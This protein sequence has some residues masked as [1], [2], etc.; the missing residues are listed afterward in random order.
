M[1]PVFYENANIERYVGSC[2]V[3]LSEKSNGRKFTQFNRNQSLHRYSWLQNCMAERLNYM[4]VRDGWSGI[5]L[6]SMANSGGKSDPGSYK[7]I[8]GKSGSMNGNTSNL[9]RMAIHALGSPLILSTN[10]KYSSGSDKKTGGSKKIADSGE[11]IKT[12]DKNSFGKPGNDKSSEK[13]CGNT[14]NTLPRVIK[15]RKRR[16][17]E[18]K[19]AQN[20]Q[21]S[22]EEPSSPTESFTEE[23]RE[24]FSFLDIPPSYAIEDKTEDCQ[25]CYCDP[26]GLVW[27]I[28]QKCPFP[29]LNTPSDQQISPLAT[30]FSAI[31]KEILPCDSDGDKTYMNEKFSDTSNSLE[32][33]SEI[34]T[35]PNGH[36]DIE[37]KF[38]SCSV[39]SDN[40]KSET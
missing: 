24:T 15:P 40:R 3:T 5:P 37:I 21:P 35:S 32:V 39:S 17:K 26:S 14:E 13:K 25:C 34:V 10:C 16:K 30:D 27:D 7:F 28:R 6:I 18:R 2:L 29:F 19:H 9:S 4:D 33:S 36:R 22:A 1:S 8:P 12:P 38:Y 23:P 20:P 11:E 31:V